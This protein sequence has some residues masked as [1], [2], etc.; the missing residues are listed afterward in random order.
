MKIMLIDVKDLEKLFEWFRNHG[1]ELEYGPHTVLLDHSELI[2]VRIKRDGREAG[3]LIAH[4]ITPY[5]RVEAKDVEDE[6]E[7]LRELLRVKHGDEKWSIPVNPVILV[8]LRDELVKEIE[9]YSDE[10]PVDDGE[11]LVKTYRDRNPG[12]DRIPRVLLA[13]LLDDLGIGK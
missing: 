10:Y 12:Y 13:R 7:Y 9:N 4:Y 8:S 3:F 1:F 11:K 2:S 6:E 5:Y